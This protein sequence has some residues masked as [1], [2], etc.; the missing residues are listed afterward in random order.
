MTVISNAQL[1]IGNNPNTINGNSLLELEGTSKG[2]LPPRIALNDVNLAAPLTGTIPEGMLIYSIGGTVTNGFYFWDGT[3]WQVVSAI[4]T[5]GNLPYA[6]LSSTT[7]QLVTSTTTSRLV[8]FE[9]EEAI[10]LI[11]HS[12]TVNPSR[13]T[14]Q[15][16]GDY[17]IT[18]SGELTGGV[19][20]VGIWL[21]ENGVDVPRSNSV[22]H[23]TG[24]DYRILTSSFVVSAN[25]NDYFE[26]VQSSTNT[27]VGL[28]SIAAGTNPTRPSIPSIVLTINKIS[29]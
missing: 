4:G 9:I 25:A 14:V 21:R 26:L 3:K 15:I 10:N 19:A 27:I 13:I 28:T 2:F 16:S 24:T 1:K 20:D 5:M 17:L 23:L 18:Y 6:S 22:S 29:D 12:T 7:T 11:T 8:N